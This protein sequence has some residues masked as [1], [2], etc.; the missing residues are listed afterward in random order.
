[1]GAS[2]PFESLRTKGFQFEFLA[3]AKAILFSDFPEAVAEL[4]EVLGEVTIPIQEI[5]A[6]GGGEA[7]GTQRLRRALFDKGWQ[8]GRFTIVK[9]INKVPKESVTHEIDHV[10]ASSNGIL[11]LEIEW[12]NKDPFF[13]RDLENFK[14]LHAEGAISAGILIT[15]GSSLQNEL[16]T[17]VRTFAELRSV[18]S[19][20]DLE[21]FGVEPTRRQRG[22]I[23]KRIGRTKQPA[24][25]RDAWTDHFVS[26][27]FGAATT[28]WSK[29]VDRINRGVGNPCPLLAIGLPSTIVT[30][31]ETDTF[32]P[33]ALGDD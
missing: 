26:D 33:D 21:K 24:S 7:K 28:H 32:A 1:M 30:F 29:L 10:R 18:D 20:S 23:E 16:R 31:E 27:K 6:S 19:F 22:A 2:D 13:D 4:V 17:L 15:R 5:V 11:A 3:H 12:N 9:E 8:K 25:F 14:R